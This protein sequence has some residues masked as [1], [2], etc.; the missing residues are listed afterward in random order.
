VSLACPLSPV[1]YIRIERA[2]AEDSRHRVAIGR[3]GA[4]VSLIRHMAANW[5]ACRQLSPAMWKGLPA[6]PLELVRLWVRVC[7]SLS[8]EFSWYDRVG[9][10]ADSRS[11][12]F[13]PDIYHRLRAHH[14]HRRFS[15]VRI[16][17]THEG[18]EIHSPR[19]VARSCSFAVGY[20]QGIRAEPWIAYLNLEVTP[21]RGT[22]HSVV[23]K[24][25]RWQQ[26]TL[27]PAGDRLS[28]KT[29][30]VS[31]TTILHDAIIAVIRNKC[32]DRFRVYNKNRTHWRYTGF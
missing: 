27:L 20:R 15:D 16:Y 31:S 18:W 3:C 17:D 7:D 4:L 21:W 23:Y 6:V 25:W 28:K 5:I 29:G 24:F 26:T 19:Y 10:R 30:V 9:S 22:P 11:P 1:T 2:M 12:T 13:I 14:Y 32:R 8:C